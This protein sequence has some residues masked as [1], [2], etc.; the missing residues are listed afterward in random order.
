MD[1]AQKKILDAQREDMI[2]SAEVEIRS[3]LRHTVL[4]RLAPSSAVV[5]ISAALKIDRTPIMCKIL[6]EIANELEQG[7]KL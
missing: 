2:K 3:A 5:A 4:S 1:E 6:R 7:G